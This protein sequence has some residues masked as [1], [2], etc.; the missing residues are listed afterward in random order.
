VTSTR[1]SPRCFSYS[2]AEARTPRASSA[3]SRSDSAGARSVRQRDPAPEHRVVLVLE[4]PEHSQGHHAERRRERAQ[5]I[6]ARPCREADGGDQPQARRGG[7][8]L[9]ADARAQDR[10]AA[11]EADAGDDRGRDARG[12]DRHEVTHAIALEVHEV[13]RDDREGRRGE[14]DDRVRAQARQAARACRAPSR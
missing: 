14:S 8:A 9:D 2:V 1:C 4:S 12:I 11:E 3:P 5:D 7:Q 13:S 6:H 10:P